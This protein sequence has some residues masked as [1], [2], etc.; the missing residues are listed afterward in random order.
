VK[1]IWQPGYITPA[2]PASPAKA[3]KVKAEKPIEV[4][5]LAVPVDAGVPMPWARRQK[6]GEDYWRGVL[7]RLHTPGLSM[8]V[9]KGA[10]GLAAMRKCIGLFNKTTR[11]RYRTARTASEVRIWRIEDA[12]TPDRFS[13]NPNHD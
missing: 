12:Q 8:A 4:D 9:P 2:A 1:T 3:E 10:P 6:R 5:W 11:Q 7:A 13:P